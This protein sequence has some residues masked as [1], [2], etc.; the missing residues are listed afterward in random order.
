MRDRQNRSRQKSGEGAGAAPD[1]GPS[2]YL[3]DTD[4][5]IYF[6][7]GDLAVVDQFRKYSLRPKAISVVTY[8]ELIYGAAKSARREENLARARR[9]SELLLI[10]NVTRPVMDTF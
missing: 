9:V 2:V 6:L 10:A 8:G 1:L 3:I 5:L 4:I 7:N